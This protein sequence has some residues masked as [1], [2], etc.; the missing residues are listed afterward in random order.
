MATPTSFPNT[1]ETN[2][3]PTFI[4]QLTSDMPKGL[5]ITQWNLQ[6]ICPSHN[7]QHKLDQLR[8]MLQDKPNETDF[9]RVTE[10]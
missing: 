7:N 4:P 5:K 9:V 3:V 1:Q 8:M 6:C 2:P 10:T